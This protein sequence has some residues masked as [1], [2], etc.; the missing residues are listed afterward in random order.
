[1]VGGTNAA[2]FLGRPV[3]GASLSSLQF[4]RQMFW[5]AMVAEPPTG[6]HRLATVMFEMFSS[7]NGQVI[8][9]PTTNTPTGPVLESDAAEAL[10][11]TIVPFPSGER[12]KMRVVDRTGSADLES[13]ARRCRRPRY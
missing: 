11:R 13:I 8:A 3:G 6:T 1:M 12:L 4:R 2:V 5:E 10:V 7:G 9:M